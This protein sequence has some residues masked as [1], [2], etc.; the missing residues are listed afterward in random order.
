[1]NKNTYYLQNRERKLY[2]KSF[3]DIND[4]FVSLEMKVK[5]SYND[6][7]L[8]RRLSQMTQKT[9]QFNLTT[10]RYSESQINDFIISDT[11]RVK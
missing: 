7:K 5:I 9:N 11:N 8:S 2:E 4:Y 1:M 3:Q 6:I 10:R